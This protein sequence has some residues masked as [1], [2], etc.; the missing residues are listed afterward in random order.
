MGETRR[1]PFQDLSSR[2][3]KSQ[4]NEEKDFS[5]MVSWIP[6][7]IKQRDQFIRL[8]ILG[9]WIGIGLLI[10]LWIV[11]RFI[12]PSLGWWVPADLH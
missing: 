2:V 9:G 8:T 4:N 5:R 3:K 1:K 7:T 11:V 10:L 12:G 6:I